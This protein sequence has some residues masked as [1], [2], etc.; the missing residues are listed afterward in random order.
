MNSL[1]HIRKTILGISQAEMAEVADVSQGT[2]SKWERGE[3]C[4]SHGE[5]TRIREEAIRRGVSWNDS[6]FFEKPESVQ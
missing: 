2:V 1:R 6:W 3:L 5:L 4:P